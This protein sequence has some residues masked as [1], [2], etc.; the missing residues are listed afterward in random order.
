[1]IEPGSP[2]TV[3]AF[4]VDAQNCFTPLCPEELPVPGGHLIVNELNA[5]A[6]VAGLR[7]GSKDAHPS[8]PVWRAVDDR[9]QLSPVKGHDN[10]D[11][12]WNLHA[13]PGTK[14]FELLEGLPL[15]TEYDYFVWKGVEPD[16]H[17]YGACFHD[18]SDQKSTGVIEFLQAKGVETVIVG[19]LA[20]DV[21]VKE[22]VLQ[23]CRAGFQVIVNLGACRSLGEETGR[24]AIEIMK[25][26]GA[27]FIDSAA[28]L[29]GRGHF[30]RNQ[31]LP[32]EQ[33]S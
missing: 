26:A 16:M 13:V 2:E 29:L 5:Q 33:E 23:L 18:L 15:V 21:C 27:Q 6:Q 12:H 14:G 22:T 11:T 30:S 7:I 17:P 1:M 19:G 20:L 32:S 24:S 8:N 9:P 3:A 4:D 10:A 31:A 28:H 25:S